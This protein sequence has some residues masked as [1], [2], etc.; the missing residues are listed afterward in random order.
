MK[1]DVLAALKDSISHWERVEAGRTLCIGPSA[2]ALCSYF[3]ARSFSKQGAAC[4][5]CPVKKHTG[6]LYCEGT[7]YSELCRH[8]D[9]VHPLLSIHIE[10]CKTCKRLAHKEVVFLR[11]LLPKKAAKP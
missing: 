1:K 8:I 2:C 9:R 7:P 11:G 4:I 10:A 3:Y 6:L 5:Y